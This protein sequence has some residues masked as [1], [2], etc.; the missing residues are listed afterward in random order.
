MS[1]PNPKTSPQRRR[2]RFW[3]TAGLSLGIGSLLLGGATS[4]WAW[5]FI[6]ND[7]APLLTRELTESLDRPVSI[8]EL[9]RVSLTG[10]RFG[11]SSVGAKADDPTKASAQA[12]EV[13]FN[14]LGGLASRQLD[15]DLTLIGADG[16]IAQDPKKGWLSFEIPEREEKKEQAFKVRVDQVSLRDSRLVAVPYAAPPQ[17]A[18]PITFQNLQGTLDFDEVELEGETAQAIRFE[19]AGDPAKG[20]KLDLSGSIQPLTVATD[21]ESATRKTLLA[22]AFNQVNMSDTYR[23]VLA[24]IN[25]QNVPVTAQDGKVSGNVKL[26]FEPEQPTTFNGTVDI[27]DG[28]FKIANLPQNLRDVDAQLRLKE[29]ELIVDKASADYGKLSPT[30]KGKVDL[31]KDHDLVGQIQDVSIEDL[32]ET[33]KFELPVDLAGVFDAEVRLT[34]P[35]AKPNING[36]VESQAEVTVDK[37]KLEGI[38]TDFSVQGSRLLLT[39]LQAQPTLGG[40]LVGEGQ[41]DWADKPLSFVFDIDGRQ[42]PA[43]AIATLYGSKSTIPLGLLAA[44]A[45]VSGTPGDVSTTVRWQA[46]QAQYPAQGVLTIADNNVITFRDTTVTL[47]RA[48]LL[49]GSGRVAN[50]QWQA[51]I[52]AINI[53]LNQFAASVPG[54]LS[55]DFELAG[56]TR[57]FSLAALSGNGNFQVQD[58]ANG[59][60][61][62]TAQLAQGRWQSNVNAANIELNRFARTLRGAV[63]GQLALGGNTNQLNRDFTLAD[64]TGSGNLSFS[65]GLAAFSPQFAALSD[66]LNARF[67]WNGQQIALEQAESNRLTA[68]GTLILQLQGSSIRGIDRFDLQLVTNNYPLAALPLPL[69]ET[70]N[71]AGLASFSGRLVGTPTTPAIDGTL[72]LNDFA[73][74]QLAFENAL[75]GRVNYD[76]SAGLGLALAGNRDRIVLNA[77]NGRDFDFALNWQDASAQGQT[78]GDNLVMQLARFPLAALDVPPNGLGEIGQ[79]RGAVSSQSIVFNLANQ[80]LVGDLAVDNLGIGYIGVERL[81]G[82]LRYANNLA[83]FTQGEIAYKDSLYQVNGSLQVG[84]DFTY[85]ASVRTD[86][87]NIQDILNTLSI[88]EIED[89]GRGLRP[90]EWTANPAVGNQVPQVLATRPTGNPQASLLDQLRRLAEIQAIQERDEIAADKAPIPPLRE[91][92]GP[93][94][95]TF[96]LQGSRS[97]GANL[98]FDLIGNQWQWGDELVADNVIAQGEVQNGILTLE[99]LR[100]ETAL[101]TPATP[102]TDSAIAS[103]VPEADP[104]VAFINLAGQFPLG[105]VAEN[106]S[107]LQLV[108]SNVPVETVRDILNLPLSLDGRLNGTATLGGNLANPQLRGVIQLADGAINRRPIESAQAQFIYQDARLGLLS[109][110]TATDNP[111]PLKLTAQIPYAFRFMDVRPSD[112]NIAIEIDVKNEGLALLNILNRQISWE[113]G[114]GEVQ[115]TVGGTLRNPEIDG[116]VNLQN[117][118]I[119]ARVL[120]EPM[121]NINGSARFVRDRIIVDGLQGQFS[122]G[123]I[124]AAGTFPLLFPIL[125]GADL[126]ELGDDEAQDDG[127]QTEATPVA[128]SPDDPLTVNLDNIALNLKGLYNGGVDGQIVV[129]GSLILGGPQIGGEVRLSRGRI[130]LPDTSANAGTSAATSTASTGTTDLSLITT[131]FERLRL[132]LGRNV[133]ITQGNL[134]NVIAD[135]TLR[136]SGPIDPISALVPEGVIRLRAGQ[137]YL[138][139]TSFRLAGRNNTAQFLPE[140]GIQ[141]PLL[142]IALQTSVTESTNSFGPTTATAFANSEVTD[143]SI[144]PFRNT[145]GSLR[146]VRIEARVN[147]PASQIF[148]NLELTSSPSRSET[149]IIGLLGGGFISALES[150]GQ[151]DFSGLLNVVSS[152]LLLRIQDFVGRTLNLSEFR[153]F[154]VT[155]ASRFSNDRNTGSTL[156]LGGEVGFDISNDFTV[157][158]L[159]I[160]TDSTPPEF[161]LRYRLTDEFTIR[162]TTNLDDINQVL[163]EFETRF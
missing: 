85:Q 120:P 58:L 75:S 10:V 37:I 83:S 112:N 92:V 15:L 30:L 47:G 57:D 22:I 20:G 115:L 106:P 12:V 144:D 149:E 2:P 53:A 14:L 64:I 13:S 38:A 74:N 123:Q 33:F 108:A 82:Q 119:Q 88:F 137:V 140:R 84:G 159:K 79:L 29:S 86:N 134:L 69:P 41:I 132:T 3:K 150:G 39:D 126:A 151:G 130:F 54:F 163:L 62:G 61:T 103:G 104:N 19:F 60:L 18:I 102:P 49:R 138:Y 131:R 52:S 56:S 25:R 63:S 34:G 118:I 121:T 66:T 1:A 81:A 40:E 5:F 21:S 109:T 161:N 43:N 80:T 128:L 113:D 65:E 50:G 127:A 146:T 27:Q 143:T 31:Q 125:T 87:G 78:Q 28:A 156:D 160:L 24:T 17:A 107:N 68:S 46:P 98:N 153:L 32:R 23:F 4:V 55:G 9:E 124:T 91:L 67:R 36:T 147:G 51:D 48:G 8:G 35:L 101:P 154:P 133:Q 70:V 94:A 11:P 71:L 157:S 100:L 26:L 72:R 162:T 105:R 114:Q 122:E 16:Y 45:T 7:L 142:N 44:T 99:P 155:S 77:A 93:F 42:L 129:G 148:D 141:D 96:N 158:I 111:E 139:T 6:R 110:L 117:A 90:P 97:R 145:T 59:T 116:F 73:V 89:F 76:R 152:A 135:G 95:G 136:L